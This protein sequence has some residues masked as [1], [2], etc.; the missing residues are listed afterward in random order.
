M[1]ITSLALW[2]LE[3]IW[4]PLTHVLLSPPQIHIVTSRTYFGQ[5]ETQ[6]GSFALFVQM[7]LY[8]KSNRANSVQCLE[9]H[10]DNTLGEPQLGCP[11]SLFTEQ[12][13]LVDFPRREEN[14]LADRHI[15]PMKEIERFAYFLLPQ[16]A[17]TG[18]PFTI[19]VTFVPRRSR[20]ATFVLAAQAP[21]T[22]PT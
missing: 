17:E 2:A 20:K 16:P 1:E 15:P 14:I 10:Y 22:A 21:N 8:N 4:T 19:K 3:K 12:G 6:T 18:H 13:W 5:H 7:R 9:L 11:N